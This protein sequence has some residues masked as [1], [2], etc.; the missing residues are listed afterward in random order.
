MR[1]TPR[2]DVAEQRDERTFAAG[3]RL[4]VVGAVVFLAQNRITS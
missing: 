3:G 1:V 2:A 4:F